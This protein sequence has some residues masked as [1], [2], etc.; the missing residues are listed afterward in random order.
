MAENDPE[1]ATRG[2]IQCPDC[3][4]WYAP[5]DIRNFGGRDY[6]KYAV[7]CLHCYEKRMAK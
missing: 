7:E 5:D 2:R 3:N 1:I 4:N 6:L